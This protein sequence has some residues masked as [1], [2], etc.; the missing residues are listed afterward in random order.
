MLCLQP[1]GIGIIVRLNTWHN[2]LDACQAFKFVLNL[3][4]KPY[5][6]GYDI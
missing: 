1:I 4:D 2:P 3:R 6:G 5:I